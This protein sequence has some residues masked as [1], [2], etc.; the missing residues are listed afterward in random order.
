[1][2]SY[3]DVIIPCNKLESNFEWK[4]AIYIIHKLSSV[5]ILFVEINISFPKI[6]LKYRQFC[7]SQSSMH[8]GEITVVAKFLVQ[9]LMYITLK[10]F[11]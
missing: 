1:M 6:C 8:N 5:Y 2:I 10:L 4:Q 9:N 7:E 11:N 3:Y